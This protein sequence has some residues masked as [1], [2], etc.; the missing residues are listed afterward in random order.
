M[1]YLLHST[2]S[3]YDVASKKFIFNLDRRISNPDTLQI[4]HATFTCTTSTNPKPSVIFM[5]SDAL[6]KMIQT[7]HT[8]ELTATNH[9]SMSNVVAVL[10][11]THDRGRYAI[12]QPTEVFR[13][14]PDSSVRIID[15]YFTDGATILD[16]E[17]AT[18]SQ[19]AV[20]VAGNDA[21]LEAIGD[22]LIGWI[23]FDNSRVFDVNY[24]EATGAGSDVHYIYNRGPNTSLIF[25]N[26]Y[27]NDMTLA[28]LG[29]TVAL[30]RNG[31]WQSAVDS[32]PVSGINALQEEFCVHSIFQVNS[33]SEF[34]WFF[35]L[36]MMKIFFM[37]GGIMFKSANGTNTSVSLSVIPLQPYLLSVHRRAQGNTYEFYWRL[38]RLSNNNVQETTSVA[39]LT[40]PANP[41]SW[42]LGHASTHFY[43]YQGPFLIHNGVNSTHIDNCRQWLKNVYAGENVASNANEV[44]VETNEDASF[45]AQLKING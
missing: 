24:V 28:N 35:D 5:R 39:G 31:S 15:V 41:G 26:N 44:V 10:T 19:A 25:V 2:N 16:G 43:H 12:Q 9:E 7:K 27:G 30:H 17:F 11:E 6:E 1:K 36:Y 8:V 18:N 29:S 21:D 13:L 32:T 3:N 37:N 23:D 4:E 22:D 38:E 42:G 34:S 14:N 33:L 40:L 45:F 20:P